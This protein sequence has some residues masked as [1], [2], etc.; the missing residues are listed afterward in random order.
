ME[1]HNKPDDN[2]NFCLVE[3]QLE[4]VEN[5]IDSIPM[6][7]NSKDGF[8]E[9]MRLLRDFLFHAPDDLEKHIGP[10]NFYSKENE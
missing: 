1:R 6:S 8:F 2:C 5:L 9:A 7:W 10:D 3:T 4:E